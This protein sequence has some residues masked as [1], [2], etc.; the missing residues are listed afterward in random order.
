MIIITNNNYTKPH[1]TS[2]TCSYKRF[3]RYKK[4][5]AMVIIK[6]IINIADINNI[7]LIK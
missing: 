2:I 7:L 3:E 6:V 1:E 4:F 5:D